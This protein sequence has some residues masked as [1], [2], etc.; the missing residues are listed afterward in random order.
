MCGGGADLTVPFGLFL[1]LPG[2]K[3]SCSQ[4]P[5]EVLNRQK[6]ENGTGCTL[7][8]ANRILH[9][10][11][12]HNQTMVEQKVNCT[13]N[14]FWQCFSGCLV[15]ILGSD[16]PSGVLIQELFLWKLH[17]DKAGDHEGLGT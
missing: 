17:G 6:M 9:V 3:I 15:V 1:S 8:G 2:L 10:Y 11:T 12:Q 5:S 7:E 16:I 4:K 14:G 13:I